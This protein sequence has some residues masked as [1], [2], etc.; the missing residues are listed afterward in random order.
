MELGGGVGRGAF[1]IYDSARSEIECAEDYIPG[2][3]EVEW[4]VVC[5]GVGVVNVLDVRGEVAVIALRVVVDADDVDDA[6]TR[7]VFRIITSLTDIRTP[8]H[9]S[10]VR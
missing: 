10:Y 8:K 2:F 7:P 9:S 3:A 1:T 4:Q 6:G 5:F